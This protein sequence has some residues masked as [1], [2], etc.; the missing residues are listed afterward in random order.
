DLGYA[1]RR[2]GLTDTTLKSIQTHSISDLDL[3]KAFETIDAGELVL[4]IDACNSGQA[5]EAK[6][7]RRGPMNS[8]G[9]AQLADAELSEVLMRAFILRRVELLA[10]GI[11]DAT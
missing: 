6:E 8:E 5:L 1:G 4:F 11:G 10:Q 7:A 9:L 3:E 2:N